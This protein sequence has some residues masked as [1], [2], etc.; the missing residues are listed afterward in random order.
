MTKA[1]YHL[2]LHSYTE[3]VYTCMAIPTW[4][5]VSPLSMVQPCK[6]SNTQSPCKTG[7]KP[8]WSSISRLSQLCD[9][10]FLSPSVCHDPHGWN[11]FVKIYWYA[12]E[13]ISACLKKDQVKGGWWCIYLYEVISLW[14]PTWILNHHSIS[15]FNVYIHVADVYSLIVQQQAVQLPPG[16]LW[17]WHSTEIKR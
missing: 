10:T 12:L 2:W 14:Y 16:P 5:M 6:E 1:Q 17:W 11:S 4:Q 8:W 7:M 9:T 3:N 13:F 15:V